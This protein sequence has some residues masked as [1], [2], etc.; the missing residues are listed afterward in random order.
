[1]LQMLTV[2]GVI[3]IHTEQN[4]FKLEKK[5][6]SFLTPGARMGEKTDI[7]EILRRYSKM[8][9]TMQE[10]ER[11]QNSELV[12]DVAERNYIQ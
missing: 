1:M 8:K 5:L 4:N 12:N 7:R 9:K 11:I 6:K 2:E 3:A 10:S